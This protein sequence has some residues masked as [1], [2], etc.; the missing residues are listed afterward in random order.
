MVERSDRCP[1]IVWP[2]AEITTTSTLTAVTFIETGSETFFFQNEVFTYIVN[3]GNF[4]FNLKCQMCM[5]QKLWTMYAIALIEG[6][7]SIIC[8]F[9]AILDFDLCAHT[10]CNLRYIAGKAILCIFFK[11]ELSFNTFYTIIDGIEYEIG[12]RIRF[13][14]SM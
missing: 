1:E 3:S 11:D 4:Y 5:T 13:L 10:I 14:Q 6:K 9:A 7:V 2:Y 8:A 12:M